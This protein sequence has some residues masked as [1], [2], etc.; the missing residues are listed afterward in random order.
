MPTNI[1]F[2]KLVPSLLSFRSPSSS[3]GAFPPPL[4]L[5]PLSLQLSDAPSR[6]QVLQHDKLPNTFYT[7]FRWGRVGENGQQSTK[8]CTSA[9]QAVELFEKKVSSYC[10]LF[11]VAVGCGEIEGSAR[12]GEG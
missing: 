10:L 1:S 12:R 11:P 4:S 8:E 5:T 7:F 3:L 2:F 6:L 9:S